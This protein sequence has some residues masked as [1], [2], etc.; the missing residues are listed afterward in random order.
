MVLLLLV[1]GLI[2]M[3]NKYSIQENTMSREI[4][5]LSETEIMEI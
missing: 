1:N 2:L 5:F 3:A 4:T